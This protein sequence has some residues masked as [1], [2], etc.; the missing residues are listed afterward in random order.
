MDCLS[1]LSVS[2][3]V[4]GKTPTSKGTLVWREPAGGR[5]KIWQSKEGPH[6]HEAGARAL[7]NA[8]TC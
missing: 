8:G 3:R 2:K 5:G 1:I 7:H 4:H 6:G